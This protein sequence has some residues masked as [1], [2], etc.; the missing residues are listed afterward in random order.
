MWQPVV[1]L[2]VCLAGNYSYQQTT[3]LSPYP[4]ATPTQHLQLSGSGFMDDVEYHRAMGSGQGVARNE[5]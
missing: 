5:L 1:V 3:D 2:H 4:K